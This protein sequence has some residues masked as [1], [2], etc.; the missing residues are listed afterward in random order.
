MKQGYQSNQFLTSP[1]QHQVAMLTPHSTPVLYSSSNSTMHAQRHN[2]SSSNSLQAQGNSLQN[3]VS[4]ES[5]ASSTS[6]STPPTNQYTD[7]F[8]SSPYYYYQQN[9]YYN[10]SFQQKD[11]SHIYLF[12]GPALANQKLIDYNLFFF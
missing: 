4:I 8:R 6:S 1:Q 3:N 9:N 12:K 5:P 2:P 11:V 7:C 10:D